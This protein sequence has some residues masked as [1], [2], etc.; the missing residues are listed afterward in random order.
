MLSHLC[1]LAI[2]I[3]VYCNITI[4]DSVGVLFYTIIARICIVSRVLLT[5]C[6]GEV[7]NFITVKTDLCCFISLTVDNVTL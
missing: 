4:I 7:E 6:N 1:L 5:M 2:I 3:K